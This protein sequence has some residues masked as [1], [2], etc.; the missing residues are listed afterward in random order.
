MKGK[1]GHQD[2]MVWQE[3][4]EFVGEIYTLSKR[5]PAEEVYG[6]TSQIRRAAVSIPSNIAEGAGRGT[7]KEFLHFLYVA[8]G[9]LA[10]VETQLLISQKLNYVDDVSKC[11]SRLERIFGLLSGLINSIRN[12]K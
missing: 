2:L 11:L 7:N 12:R 8:R 3:S 4:I 1:R 5:F 9:S 6:L 10:E